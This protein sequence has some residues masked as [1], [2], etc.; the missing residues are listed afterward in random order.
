MADAV[1]KTVFVKCPVDHAFV[2]FTERVD[3]WWPKSHRRLEDSRVELSPVGPEGLLQEVAG[4]RALPIGFVTVWEPGVRLGFGWHLGAPPGMST[5][6][7]IHFHAEADGT[8]VELVHTDGDPA[9]PDWGKTA[10]IFTN[11]WTHVLNSYAS[12]TVLT[13]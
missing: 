13:E 1:R 3:G 7:D 6:V 5:R 12:A 2:V 4:D 10:R 11:A 8:R 9:I